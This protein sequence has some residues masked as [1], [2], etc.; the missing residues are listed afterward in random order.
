MKYILIVLFISCIS[1]SPR[2]N[3]QKEVTTKDSLT[4]EL[5]KVYNNGNLHG[6]SI[7]LVN[8]K[9]A[10][11]QEAFGFANVANGKKYTLETR[12]P[13]ASISKTLVGISLLK[14]Q[15]LGKINLDDPINKYL[16]F[17]VKNPFYPEV[18]I[19]IR[20]L[21][22]H[23]STIFDTDLYDYSSY[24]LRNDDH[25]TA[26]YPIKAYD[27]FNEP[28]E[29]ITILD[30]MKK[31]IYTD[32][33][34]CCREVFLNQK[35]GTNYEYSNGATTLAAAILELATDM[36][37]TDFTKKHIFD[38]LEMT[39]SSW[40]PNDTNAKFYHD[41]DTVYADY[42]NLD[43]PAG[44]LVTNNKDISIFLQ[45]LIKGYSGSASLLS[46][47]SYSALF[48]K[49]FFDEFS[50]ESFPGDE[51]PFMNIKYDE[52]VF[53]GLAPKGYVGH[54]GADPGTITFMFF[55]KHTNKGFVFITN[56]TIWWEFENALKDL[57]SIMDILEQHT[58]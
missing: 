54:T 41:A 38:P 15:E 3:N 44:G 29:R 58:S 12:Q 11:Y 8:E 40:N 56:R 35:P 16:P 9:E 50:K 31:M 10:F 45:E 26:S 36:S 42:Y 57:W 33:E 14:A 17:S 32:E 43:Y 46:K 24:F 47:E 51:N 52:G 28:K 18:D 4:N 55:N 27:Y 23:T 22:N 19:T 1:C 25:L 7:S 30:F 2:E 13:I 48:N 53:M 34:S 6:F 49:N 21:S 20:H 39:S 5:K 37:F